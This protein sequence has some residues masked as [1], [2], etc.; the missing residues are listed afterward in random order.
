MILATGA[1][2]NTGSQVVR[3]LRKVARVKAGASGALALNLLAP[4]PDDERERG[5]RLS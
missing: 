3:E 2:G 4:A 1:T 5:T